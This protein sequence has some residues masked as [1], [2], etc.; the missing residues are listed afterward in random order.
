M[1]PLE[2]TAAYVPFANGGYRPSVHFINKIARRLSGKAAL[3]SMNRGN[4]PR[5]MRPEVVGMMNSMTTETIEG[6]TAGKAAF[7][8]PAAG[9]TGTSQKSRDAWFCGF[10]GNHVAAVWFGNDDYRPTKNLTGG[11]LP[12]IAWQ[13]FML[14]A[15]EGVP[16]KALPGGWTRL[17]AGRAGRP[18][19]GRHWRD[20]PNAGARIP[21][22]AVSGD[23][24]PADI[25]A[26]HP[27]APIKK[28]VRVSAQRQAFTRTAERDT[29]PAR[30]SAQERRCR[31][32]PKKSSGKPRSST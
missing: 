15:H 19:A 12:T 13:K 2:L 8:W 26:G 9:K 22:A 27:P 11:T 1:T 3:P 20:R 24:P 14:A 31:P 18:S 23:R 29:K 16:M 7:G 10:T 32:G 6:G 21:A 4:R 5:V 25:P 28:P 17:G 30:S